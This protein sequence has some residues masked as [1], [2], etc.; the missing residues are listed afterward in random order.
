MLFPLSSTLLL[1]CGEPSLDCTLEARASVTVRVVD[2]RGQPRP[3]ARVTFTLDGGA[4]QLALCNGGTRQQGD[5]DSCL[6][7]T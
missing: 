6:G 2:G 3:D 4:E 7:Q 1:A 5:C